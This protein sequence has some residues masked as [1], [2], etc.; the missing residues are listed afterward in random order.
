[1]SLD[2][3]LKERQPV[4]Q[5]LESIVDGLYRHGPCRTAPQD[6][7]AM[8][9]LYQSACADLARL[10]ALGGDPADVATLNRLVIRAHGQIYRG[11]PARSWRPLAFFLVDYPRL[12][13]Q[14]WKF[15]LASF[16]IAAASA[17][18]AYSTVQTSPQTVGD[19]LGGAD[20]E[21]RG[22]KTLADIRERFGHEGSP[23][24]S[25]F[26]I[27]NNIRVALT[28]F[29]LGITLGLG[30]IYI[31]TVNG[32]MLGG[33]AGAFA[34][35]HAAGQFWGVVLPHG[36]LELSAVVVAGGAGL[37]LGYG[38]WAPGA[39][40]RRRALREDAVRAMRLAVGLLPAFAFAGIIEGFVTP[41]DAIPEPL[42][43]ALGIAAAAVFWLYLLLAGRTPPLPAKDI[44][45]ASAI[46]AAGSAATTAG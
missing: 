9:E 5:R 16:L 28:A 46:S 32:A 7:V 35:S 21:V 23:V 13:R 18:M 34:K 43:L 42:K 12:F 10:R 15:T 6:L 3:W 2:H 44:K 45:T 27:T 22:H 29:A 38:L 41:S 26:V 1:M 17:L 25:S 36:T 20:R 37:L 19:I 8:I 30:T 11:G 39:R 40:T 33:I 4:W 31:L 14:T 24:L